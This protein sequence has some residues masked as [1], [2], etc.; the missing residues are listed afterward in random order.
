M[1]AAITADAALPART[2]RR[3]IEIS[4]EFGISILVLFKWPKTVQSRYVDHSHGQR[5]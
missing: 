2:P 4:G 5:I 1:V 3:E